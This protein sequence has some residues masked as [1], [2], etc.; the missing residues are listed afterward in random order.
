MAAEQSVPFLSDLPAFKKKRLFLRGAN[1]RIFEEMPSLRPEPAP[2]GPMTP[3]EEA[4][5]LYDQV[6]ESLKAR[7]D[8]LEPADMWT[9][10]ITITTALLRVER[11]VTAAAAE[12]VAAINGKK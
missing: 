11:A 8:G 2:S 1:R 10:S 4:R 6:H 12:I 5:R 9:Q 3:L 7:I